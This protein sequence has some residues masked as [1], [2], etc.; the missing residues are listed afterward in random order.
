MRK[1][2]EDKGKLP[3]RKIESFVKKISASEINPIRLK[4][5]KAKVREDGS[6]KNVS[7]AP[8]PKHKDSQK[9]TTPS[10]KRS[11]KLLNL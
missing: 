4:S 9:P 7:N 1:E 8:S 11:R 10:K 2:L 6:R 5:Q 3:P